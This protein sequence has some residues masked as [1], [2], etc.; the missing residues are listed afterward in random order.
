M[1]EEA[2]IRRASRWG[3]NMISVAYLP[4]LARKFNAED[5]RLQGGGSFF[6][7]RAGVETAVSSGKR[8]FTI[9]ADSGNSLGTSA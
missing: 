1:D 5:S 2:Q 9:R 3:N 8:S 6:L 4:S 7:P